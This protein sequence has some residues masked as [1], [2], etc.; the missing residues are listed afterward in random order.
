[1]T[2]HKKLVVTRTKIELYVDGVLAV[3]GT[4]NY[5]DAKFTRFVIGAY[6]GGSWTATKDG[7]LTIWG[8]VVRGK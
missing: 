5:K 3:S 4:V 1:M 8:L 7:T 6:V 2:Y